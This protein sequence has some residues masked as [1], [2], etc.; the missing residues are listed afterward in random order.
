MS[1]FT[2]Y[3]D[4]DD[5]ESEQAVICPFPHTTPSGQTYYEHNPSAHVNTEESLFHCKACGK[6]YSERQFI[7]QILDC[8]PKQAYKLSTAFYND[9]DKRMWDEMKEESQHSEIKSILNITSEVI[10]ELGI[11]THLGGSI[12]YP[13]FMYDKL[14]DIRTYNPTLTPK[15]RSRA[16][17]VAGLI[18]PFDIWKEEPKSRTTL[19]CAGEKDMAMA[20]SLGFNAITLTGGENA[21]PVQLNAF[22]DTNVVILYDNDAPGLVGAIRL[23]M[24]LRPLCASVK[25]VTKF[26]EVC[27][28]NGEDLYDFFN[29]YGKTREDLIEIMNETTEFNPE[30]YPEILAD[31]KPVT[32]HDAGLPKN[33]NKTL[34]SNVQVTAT[35]EQTFV[36]PTDILAK[37]YKL[38]EKDDANSMAVGDTLE[39]ELEEDT[40]KDLLHFMDNNFKEIDILKNT[41]RILK[42]PP[43]EQAVSIKTLTTATIY[44]C[45]VTDMFESTTDSIKQTEYVAYSVNTKL[46]SGKKYKITY[47]L[48]PH[49]YKGQVLVMVVLSATEAADTVD[50]FKINPKV[51]EHLSKFQALTGSVASRMYQLSEKVKGLLGY[52]GNT[53]LI[54]TLDL[55]YHTPLQ[56]N[57]GKFKE[58]RAYIDMILVGESRVG[59]SSTA[60]ALRKCY[61]LGTMTSLA[62]NSATVPGLIGGSNKVNGSF[63]TRAGIIPQSHRGLMIFEEFGKCNSNIVRELTDIRSSNEVRITRV[64]GTLTLP[65]MVRMIALT[66]VKNNTGE[67]KSIASYPNG[68]SVITDLV[69]SAEDIARY[70]IMLVLA[71]RGTNAVDPFWQPEEPFPDEVYQARIRWVWSRTAEQIIIDDEVGHYLIEKA[72]ELNEAYSC[73]IKIFGTEAWKKLARLAIATAG[74]LVSTDETYEKLIV[75]KEH[76]D[77]AVAYY[78]RIYDN[79]VFKLGSYVKHERKYSVIDDDGVSLLQSCFDRAPGLVLQLEQVATSNKAMLQSASGLDNQEYNSTMSRL[80]RGMFIKYSNADIIPT[81][82][83][84]LGMAKINRSTSVRGIGDINVGLQS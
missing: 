4:L 55:A 2:R 54:Q 31:L 11:I 7:Q 71:D 76:V 52:N 58:V 35:S 84:R 51:I 41:R 42:I 72:N 75:T 3:F 73:H 56:F 82:R 24:R 19:L 79:D 46:E 29:K 57:L 21:K 38:A 5:G 65:A 25:V 6:G 68:I 48:V 1:F 36:A 23:A 60:D 44:K 69:G 70:D 40:A 12:M 77:F 39:W 28:E 33:L 18:I 26:H 81:E 37:K 32:L 47:R 30:D 83:F 74:Y 17:S 63:Q 78:I 67:I 49:P 80:V 13:V 61:Q 20:R 8:K 53:D 64:S 14:V 66:N 50:S 22:K 59:K 15:V 10:N 43:K 45:S 62:G 34:V 27:V 9:E 16:G